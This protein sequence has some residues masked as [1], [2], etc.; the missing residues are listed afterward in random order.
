[1]DIDKLLANI[2]YSNFTHRIDK[3]KLVAPEKSPLF[4][5][6]ELRSLREDEIVAL[7]RQG[8]I[9]ADWKSI[10]VTGNFK[11]D[12]VWQNHFIGCVVLGH[13]SGKKPPGSHRRRQ[14]SHGDL[15]VHHRGQP[16][17]R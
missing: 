5:S 4:P 12:R 15:P 6:M 3:L 8:N 1:M 11:P 17:R 10:Q 16:Y 14:P 2:N 7:E 9:S 13:Y